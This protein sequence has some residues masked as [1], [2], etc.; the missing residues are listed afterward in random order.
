MARLHGDSDTKS[1][2]MPSSAMPETKQNPP[3]PTEA[4]LHEAALAYLARYA[5]SRAG[6]IRALDRKVARWARLSPEAGDEILA[7]CRAAVRRVAA[8]L[9]QAGLIDDAQFAAIRAR[10]LTRAGKSRR[11]VAAH[12]GARGIGGEILDEAL[13]ENAEAEFAACLIL[14]R[15]RRIGPF[16]PE[17]KPEDKMRELGVLARAGFAQGVAQRALEI[18][19]DEAETL[20]IG[21]RR[22]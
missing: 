16:R 10:S 12:L 17:E 3:V 7:Q 5:A 2:I 11:A 22:G 9:E 14:A 18:G 1:G 8:R 19:R 13:P 6:V 21:L 20:I 4:T 15:K